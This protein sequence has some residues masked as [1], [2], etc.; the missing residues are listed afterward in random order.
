MKTIVIDTNVLLRYLRQDNPDLFIKAKAV[1]ADTRKGNTQLYFDETMVAETIWVLLKVFNTPRNEIVATI[2]D[3]L[4][5]NWALNPRKNA[6]LSALNLFK[7]HIELSYVD[8]WLAVLAKDS[9]YKLETFD[10]KLK[11]L[12]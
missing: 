6:I 1:F 5:Q 9:G 7:S 8:C 10:K 2:S 11:K 4:S 12:K 3:L